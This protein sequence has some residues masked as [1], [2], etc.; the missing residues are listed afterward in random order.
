MYMVIECRGY[1]IEYT[2]FSGN[3]DECI[4]WLDENT[5]FHPMNEALKVSKELLVNGNGNPFTYQIRRE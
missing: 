3:K 4:E 1:G 2:V 5:E